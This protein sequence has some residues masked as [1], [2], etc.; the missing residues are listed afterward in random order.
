[1]SGI[2]R[3]NLEGSRFLTGVV[4]IRD[5]VICVLRSRISSTIASWSTNNF[6]Q[7]VTWSTMIVSAKAYLSWSFVGSARE[8]FQL[9]QCRNS[10]HF[11]VGN[12]V[13]F[14]FSLLG[15]NLHQGIVS[16]LSVKKSPKKFSE[17]RFPV[18]KFAQIYVVQTPCLNRDVFNR[19][20]LKIVSLSHVFL[21]PIQKVF[22]SQKIGLF[23]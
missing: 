16:T 6:S 10:H 9:I 22:Q 21:L 11:Q 4:S 19:I 13:H 3:M 20:V 18:V 15:Q 2:W 17:F 1:M 5:V 12:K 23:R 8:V 14:C 7:Y